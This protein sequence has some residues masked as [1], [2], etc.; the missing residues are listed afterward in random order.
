MAASQ[1]CLCSRRLL[2]LEGV[3]LVGEDVRGV[4]ASSE[5]SRVRVA[6]GK[7]EPRICLCNL[8]RMGVIVLL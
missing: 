7:V 1:S 2:F 4:G 5:A 8:A 3:S 6:L